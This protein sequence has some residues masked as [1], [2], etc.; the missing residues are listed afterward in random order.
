M[1]TLVLN[2]QTNKNGANSD[3]PRAFK[4]KSLLSVTP[5]RKLCRNLAKMPQTR[6]LSKAFSKLLKEAESCENDKMMLQKAKE[7]MRD[8]NYNAEDV[9]R[10]CI[11]ARI[12]EERHEACFKKCLVVF[13]GEI[14][15]RE[16]D[17]EFVLPIRRYEINGFNTINT[18]VWIKW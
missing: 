7:L 15:G 14:V 5:I 8:L 18:H 1:T 3:V 13:L 16:Q 11:L 6:Q 17:M 9:Q 2:G 10:F 12:Y 4:S